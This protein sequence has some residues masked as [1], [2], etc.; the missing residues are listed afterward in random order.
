[1]ILVLDDKKVSMIILHCSDS[2]I[3][4]QDVAMINEWHLARGFDMIGYHWFITKSGDIQ[5]GRRLSQMGAHCD[6]YN[7]CSIGICLAGKT[8]FE[9]A[10][11]ESLRNLLDLMHDE[12][13]TAT[14]HGHREF[15]EQKTC[16]N[17][18]YSD[19]REFWNALN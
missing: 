5:A 9:P 12:F 18:D 8:S 16:P 13:P 4:N 2:E 6:G 19:L 1:M 11:F 10:Q 3:P 17:L 14:L 7:H 15:N